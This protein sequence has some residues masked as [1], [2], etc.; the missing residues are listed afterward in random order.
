MV[1]AIT[2]ADLDQALQISFKTPILLK[3]P[4]GSNHCIRI[5]LHR[6]KMT[7]RKEVMEKSLVYCRDRGESLRKRAM[8][9][10]PWWGTKAQ[11]I[12]DCFPDANSEPEAESQLLAR[13]EAVEH[14]IDDETTII[15]PLALKQ[16]FTPH[17]V[18][19]MLT[20]RGFRSPRSD[21]GRICTS[22]YRVLTILFK[23][24]KVNSIGEFLREGIDDNCLPLRWKGEDGKVHGVRSTGENVN[25][26]GWRRADWQNFYTWQWSVLTP[27]FA[28]RGG[29]IVHYEFA[30]RD[31]LPIIEKVDYRVI[32]NGDYSESETEDT[33]QIRRKNAVSAGNCTVSRI[34]IHPWSWNF[35]DFKVRN[36]ST[37][38]YHH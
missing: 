10:D 36:R 19:A 5:R 35:G 33:L 4:F 8:D 28:K 23:I 11:E 18:E 13:I 27:F 2:N 34:K 1:T 31:I 7:S 17:F 37:H 3:V 32:A 20:D 38:P 15:P 30:S 14:E 25:L 9:S 24:N 21:A 26:R 6:K 22:F 16:A 29:E 12:N